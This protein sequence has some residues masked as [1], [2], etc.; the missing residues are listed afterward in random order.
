[1]II[2]YDLIG[3][4]EMKLTPNSFQIKKIKDP[5]QTNDETSRLGFAELSEIN[6]ISNQENCSLDLSHLSRENQSK[7]KKLTQEYSPKNVRQY[8]IEMEIILSDEI[9]VN[10]K[11]RR[12]SPFERDELD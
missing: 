7:I 9:P 3:K 6:Y 10:T 11:P 4:C 12:L 1:M 5:N 2:G 8:P